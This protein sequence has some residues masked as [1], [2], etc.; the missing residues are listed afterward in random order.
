MK[1]VLLLSIFIMGQCA[2]FTDYDYPDYEQDE[3]EGV[4]KKSA[5]RRRPSTVDEQKTEVF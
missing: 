5:L 4:M 1:T 3:L 2:N